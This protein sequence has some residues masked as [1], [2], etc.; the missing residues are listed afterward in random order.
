MI[1]FQLTRWFG[2]AFKQDHPDV[3]D[4]C[5][6][7]FVEND[8]QAYAATCRMLGAFDVRDGLSRITAPTAILVGEDDL[9]TPPAMS[10]EMHQLIPHSTYT[11]LPQARHL[12][13]L[14]RPEVV[15]Q[16]IVDLASKG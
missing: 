10:Q 14:E 4:A 15:A 8:V 13:P 1:P 11:V 9:A 16:T 2:D 12:T 6:K 3:V 5:V 7:T